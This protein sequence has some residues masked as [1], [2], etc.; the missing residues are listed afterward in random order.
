MKISKG[1]VGFEVND[2][3]KKIDKLLET[4]E[5]VTI[6]PEFKGLEW[7]VQIM[8]YLFSLCSVLI[9]ASDLNWKR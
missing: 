1:F 4:I 7:F 2:M 5:K 8:K 9:I 6:I 3:D